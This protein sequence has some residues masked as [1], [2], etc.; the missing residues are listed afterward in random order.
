MYAVSIAAIILF[1]NKYLNINFDNETVIA[2]DKHFT[3]AREIQQYGNL[4]IF[5]W[6]KF[7]GR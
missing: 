5:A 7:S 4:L 2:V 1:L 6:T 3:R